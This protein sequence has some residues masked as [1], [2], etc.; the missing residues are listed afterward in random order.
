MTPSHALRLIKYKKPLNGDI[1]P[2]SFIDS[3]KMG[4]ELELIGYHHVLDGFFPGED[5]IEFKTALDRY[6]RIAKW[7][8]DNGTRTTNSGTIKT[9]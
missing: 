4:E 3:K 2:M 9:A 8:Q 1:Q 5:E 6:N 7:R